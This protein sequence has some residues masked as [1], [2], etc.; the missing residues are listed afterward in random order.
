MNRCLH[1]E[2]YCSQKQFKAV[3]NQEIGHSLVWIRMPLV[4]TDCNVV[5]LTPWTY[6][7]ISHIQINEMASHYLAILVLVLR[8]MP[9]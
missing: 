8:L 9:V 5:G 4:C 6:I 3:S 7:L 1:Q 2:K